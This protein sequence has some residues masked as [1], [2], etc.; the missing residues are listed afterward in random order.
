MVEN[1]LEPLYGR[2][3]ALPDALAERLA[4]YAAEAKGAFAPAT[5]K[6]LISD[7]KIWAAWCEGRGCCLFPAT[8]DDLAAFVDDLAGIDPAT[9]EPV[10][11]PKRRTKTI[12]RYLSSIAHMHRAAG[13]T[14]PASATVVGLALKRMRRALTVRPR[15]TD[16]LGEVQIAT[17]IAAIAEAGEGVTG[18]RDTA[19]LL[20]MRDSLCRASEVA[21]MMWDNLKRGENGAG[22]MLVARS[23]TDQDGQG[24]V[25]WLSP[26]SMAALE[27]WRQAHDI[28]L[29]RLSEAEER[30]YS[31]LV[32]VYGRQ[33]A[34]WEAQLAHEAAVEAR[35]RGNLEAK[36]ASLPPRPRGRPMKE[37]PVEPRRIE[38]TM[39]GY[40]FRPLFKGGWGERLVTAD[41]IAIVR[42]RTWAAGFYE[43]R[44]TAHSTRV[45]GVQDHL[46]DGTDLAALMQL[47]GWKSP[48]MPARYGERLL[49][50]RGAAAEKWRR[51]QSQ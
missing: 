26:D 37:P 39:T 21:E 17:V 10:G 16:P 11:P 38:W 18:L 49:A 9:K 24:R 47:G 27:A 31:K 6:A 36:L 22:T 48:A 4:R 35:R 33:V 19:L 43:G 45:G 3:P 1:A 20:V 30:R 23:K 25:V 13:L 5:E 2:I 44:Y 29:A 7:T 14:S 46:A 15:Q 42:R 50:E 8:P 51:R 12:E 28:E 34:T 41:I 40:V 32:E